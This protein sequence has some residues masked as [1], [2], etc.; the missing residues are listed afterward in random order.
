MTDQISIRK[1]FEGPASRKQMFSLFDRH[2]KRPT[3]GH[4]EPTALY[5]GEWFEISEAEHD[6]MFEILPPLWIRG[7]IF[8]MRE[9]MTGSVTSVFFA[10]RIDGALRH[11]HGYCDLSD[12]GSVEAMRLA[13]ID[14]ESR[15]VRAMTREERL[16]HIWSSTAEAYRGYAGDRWPRALQ[17]ERTVMIWSNGKGTILKLLNDLTDDE[18]AA[19][20]P[21]QFR[22]LPDAV[23]A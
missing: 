3:R 4:D 5:T 2:A 23:A 20:L 7:S 11:F 10:L 13:I 18:I 19:K 8:A 14:R 22:Q 21:V 15:P 6:Y 12:R 9:F 1:V 17:G 16:E